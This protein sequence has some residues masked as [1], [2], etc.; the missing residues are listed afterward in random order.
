MAI[1]VSVAFFKSGTTCYVK[2]L[3]NPVRAGRIFILSRN[4]IS[5]QGPKVT[6]AGEKSLLCVEGI[7]DGCVAGPITNSKVLTDRRAGLPPH[8]VYIVAVRGLTF[9]NF[10]DDAWVR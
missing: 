9:V 5:R 1:G 4:N 8:E 10:Y 7:V 2:Q 6:R 3:E